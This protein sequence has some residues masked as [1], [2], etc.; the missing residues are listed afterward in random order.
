[1]TTRHPTDM[2]GYGGARV[3]QRNTTYDSCIARRVVP[4]GLP[5]PPPGFAIHRKSRMMMGAG[6]KASIDADLAPWS[7]VSGSG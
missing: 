7:G 5:R 2:R 6:R 1:M 3:D 4:A